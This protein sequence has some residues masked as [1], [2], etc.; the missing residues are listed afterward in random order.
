MSN[1]LKSN[2]DNNISQLSDIELINRIAKKE[3][4]AFLE[5]YKRYYNYLLNFVFIIIKNHYDS[6]DVVQETFI[7]IWEKAELYDPELAS[8]ST[9]LITIARNKSLD[10]LRKLKNNKK[11]LDIDQHK[12]KSNLKSS[13]VFIFQKR[14]NKAIKKAIEKLPKKQKKIINIVYLEGFTHKEAASKLNLPL[15]T[16]KT[17]LRLGIIKLR[18]RIENETVKIY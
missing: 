15:G 7:Q 1:N 14:R 16:V 12:I 9:W 6:E 8:F 17:R 4:Q 2:I 18:N 3:E 11:T 13:S 10:K 5:I